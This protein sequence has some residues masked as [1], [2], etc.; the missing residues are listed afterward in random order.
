MMGRWGVWLMGALA[1][2]P[3]PLLRGTPLVLS[4]Y[5]RRLV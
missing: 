5:S 2:L 3:L 4:R 1:H